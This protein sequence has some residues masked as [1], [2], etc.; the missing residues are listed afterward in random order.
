MLN[1]QKIII[2][3]DLI[4]LIVKTGIYK[5]IKNLELYV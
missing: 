4:I 5:T 3:P 1:T 2:N